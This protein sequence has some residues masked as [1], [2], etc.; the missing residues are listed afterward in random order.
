[1]IIG[2]YCRIAALFTAKSN[3][4]HLV[5]YN[6]KETHKLVKNGIYR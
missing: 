3:F 5:A 4:T 2:Q 6:K 1:M